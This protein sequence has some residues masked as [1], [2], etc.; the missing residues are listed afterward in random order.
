MVYP[1]RE[2]LRRRR[3]AMTWVDEGAWGRTGDADTDFPPESAHGNLF[4]PKCARQDRLSGNDAA[5][6]GEA[7]RSA[8]E[9]LHTSQFSVGLG[10][11]VISLLRNERTS[12]A[13]TEVEAKTIRTSGH[14]CEELR[15]GWKQLGDQL[16]AATRI[17][18]DEGGASSHGTEDCRQLWARVVLARGRGE[19]QI[20]AGIDFSDPNSPQPG[21]V[22]IQAILNNLQRG[23]K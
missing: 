15:Q 20:G 18:Q 6:V 1:R 4:N 16:Q 12:R 10:E 11:Y 23:G 21:C 14:G 3:R 13:L 19:S 22:A 17:C 7:C 2:K 5:V 9:W 8:D